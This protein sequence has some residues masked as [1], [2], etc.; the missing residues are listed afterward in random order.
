[1]TEQ[2]SSPPSPPRSIARR[3]TD[4]PLAVLIPL[5]ILD[6]LPFTPS[7]V[8]SWLMPVLGALGLWQG[9]WTL[10]APIPDAINHRI[11]AEVTF[12]DAP[13]IVWDSPD[14]RSQSV[15][16]R[17]LSH[18]ESEFLERIVADSNS[19]AWPEFAQSLAR[20]L[21]PK[22]PERV[23]LFVRTS[24][25]P[26]PTGIWVVD[27]P[28]IEDERLMF[29]LIYPVRDEMSPFASEHSPVSRRGPGSA[30]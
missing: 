24:E 23:E 21:S 6:V 12:D 19:A 1:M 29:T 27:P 22:R 9:S 14:W 3:V 4:L 2:D 7:V 13:A 26:P 30:R 17:F 15:L 8:R 16:E 25:I 5:V 11:R 10:F 20:S 18:R 28:C